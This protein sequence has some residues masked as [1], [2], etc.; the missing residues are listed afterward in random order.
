[1]DQLYFALAFALLGAALAA[2]VAWLIFRRRAPQPPVRTSRPARPPEPANAPLA[3]KPEVPRAEARLG[4]AT[5]AIRPAA[6]SQRLVETIARETGIEH[7]LVARVV[8]AALARNAS[9]APPRRPP[10]VESLLAATAEAATLPTPRVRPSAAPAPLIMVVDDSVTVRVFAQRLLKAAGYRV[11]LAE[12]GLDALERLKEE[13]PSV[14]LADIEMPRMDGFDLARHIRADGA[15]A[16]MPI[17]VITSRIAHK[18]REYARQI[19][20]NHYLGKPYAPEEL[21]QL[22]RRYAV[23]GSAVA[24]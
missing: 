8:E 4:A 6:D 16:H 21:I 10:P 5:A 11:V 20:V 2:A 14:V 15:L 13:R 9:A 19:G 17:I 7:A 18:H 24:A 23:V 1:M 12:D 3:A 22:V